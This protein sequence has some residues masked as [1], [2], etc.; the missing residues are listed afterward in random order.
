MSP[1]VPTV[2]PSS[3]VSYM[4]FRLLGNP[5]VNAIVIVIAA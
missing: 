2:D 3:R 5:M 1:M 4:F